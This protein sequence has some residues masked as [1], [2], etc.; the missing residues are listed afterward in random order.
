M[1]LTSAALLKRV[2]EAERLLPV[3]GCS[4]V[5]VTLVEYS[6]ASLENISEEFRILINHG[7]MHGR[8]TSMLSWLGE[9][10]SIKNHTNKSYLRS[11][12]SASVADWLGS[13]ASARQGM[14]SHSLFNLVSAWIYLLSFFLHCLAVYPKLS[15][16]P[17][18]PP[19]PGELFPSP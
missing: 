10:G 17:L 7:L 9:K 16:L 6:K 4:T 2:K 14:S 18:P 5:W 8:I 13:H 3:K 19:S 11:V 15:S 12:V 1:E